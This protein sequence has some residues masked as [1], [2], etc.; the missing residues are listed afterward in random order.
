LET[1]LWRTTGLLSWLGSLWTCPPP[2]RCRS[3][4]KWTFA[5]CTPPAVWASLL[6]L[7]HWR[8]AA[9]CRTR[10]VNERKVTTEGKRCGDYG[11]QKHRCDNGKGSPPPLCCRRHP[12]P[13]MDERCSTAGAAPQILSRW[14]R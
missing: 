11:K 9:T 13:T 3:R 1:P 4:L 10:C 5:G 8:W 7:H 14:R 6:G 2:T 12:H